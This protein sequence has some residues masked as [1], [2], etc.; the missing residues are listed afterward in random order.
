V[1]TDIHLAEDMVQQ[2]VSM[3][4]VMN[5]RVGSIEGMTFLGRQSDY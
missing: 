3:S 4:R 1:W 2:R 5:L